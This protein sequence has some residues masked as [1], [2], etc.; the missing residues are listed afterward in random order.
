[1]KSETSDALVLR[2]ALGEERRVAKAAI[3]S[4]RV[5]ALSLMPEGLQSALTL[6]E[7]SD[8][9][10]YLESLRGQPKSSTDR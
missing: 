4:R 1:M 3:R 7:F 6:E 10:A 9:V 8:L 5:S 2:T